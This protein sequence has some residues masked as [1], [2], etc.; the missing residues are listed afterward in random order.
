[1]L[2]LQ[3]GTEAWIAAGLGFQTG[4]GQPALD[5]SEALPKPLSLPERRAYLDAYVAWGHSIGA[6][7]ERDGLV[8]FPAFPA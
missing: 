3:G 4:T 8:R 6:A 7:L 2:V 5:A 1:V